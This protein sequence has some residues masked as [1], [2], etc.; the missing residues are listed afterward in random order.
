M[1]TVIYSH[2]YS[3]LEYSMIVT[4]ER[5]T[6]AIR[7]EYGGGKASTIYIPEHKTSNG[8]TPALREWVNHHSS[9]A[10][11]G[12]LVPVAQHALHVCKYSNLK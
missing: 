2:K 10:G 5:G 7:I 9:S 1:H 4:L 8:L 11:C 6:T 12:A 3:T